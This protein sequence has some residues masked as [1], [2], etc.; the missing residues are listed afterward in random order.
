M[1]FL[2]IVSAIRGF[3]GSDPLEVKWPELWANQVKSCFY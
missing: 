1:K 2:L 3:P